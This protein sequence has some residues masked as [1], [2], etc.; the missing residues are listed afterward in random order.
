MNW[1][2]RG[3]LLTT[4]ACGLL[5][6]GPPPPAR[7]ETRAAPA[8]GDSLV[9]YVEQLEYDLRV[10]EIRGAARADS[11]RIALDFT[12]QRL[13]WAL[14]DRAR[15]YEKPGLA[16]MAGAVLALVVFGQVVKVTF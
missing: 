11:L 1:H 8:Q 10:C 4:L 15:W 9:W 3:L 7:A 14:E 6:L 12:G 2:G 13:A 16:F 5:W